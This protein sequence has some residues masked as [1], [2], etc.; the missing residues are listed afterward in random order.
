MILYLS[1]QRI[2]L[3]IVEK[4]KLLHFSITEIIVGNIIIKATIH[5]P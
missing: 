5:A 2:N 4:K 1:N 3:K